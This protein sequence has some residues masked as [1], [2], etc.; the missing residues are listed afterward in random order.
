MTREE[1]KKV[2]E[3]LLF[4]S[5][6]PVSINNFSEILEDIDSREIRELLNEL[7]KEYED[8][9]KPV[10]I[11]EIAGGFQFATDPYYAPWIRK[12]YKQDKHSRISMPALE[13]LAVIAYRQPITR[14]EIEAIR[15]VNVDGVIHSLLERALIKTCGRKETAGRP[16]LYS[17]T[18]EFLK[19]FG[20]NSLNELPKLKEFSE[21]DI[22]LGETKELD[23]EKG[24]TDGDQQ[25]A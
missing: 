25:T 12:L 17:T 21:A 2:I 14:S 7:K 16:I 4:A 24:E 8:T 1:A 15:G 18:T 13:T 9:Q 22:K 10:S 23:L 3:A 6:K 11:T 19:H 5:N 20:L